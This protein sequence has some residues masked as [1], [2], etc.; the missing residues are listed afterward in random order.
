[1][2]HRFPDQ[3]DEDLDD[4]VRNKPKGIRVW[5]WLVLCDDGKLLIGEEIAYAQSAIRNGD[6]NL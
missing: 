5:T 6:I 3:Q 4:G 2:A 1:M